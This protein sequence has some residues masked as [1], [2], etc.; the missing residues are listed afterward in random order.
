MFSDPTFITASRDLV[1]VRLESYESKEH[2]TKVRELLHGSFANTAFC[3]LA[4]DGERQLSSAGRSP[5]SL[6]GSRGGRFSGAPEEES[7]R[8]IAQLQVILKDFPP[9]KD[10]SQAV[11]QDFHTFRQALNVASGDQ[12]ILLLTVAS[13]ER[14][15]DLLPTLKKTLNDGKMI[16]RYHH[17]FAEGEG[18]KNWAEQ[19][20]G[21]KT[22]AKSGY[23]IIRPDR[24]GLK[25]EV[26]THLPLTASAG[27]LSAALTQANKD[28]AKD[29]ERKVY[30]DHVREARRNGAYF[31]N[32]VPYGEDRDGDGVIDPKR[33]RGRG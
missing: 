19:V 13:P 18:D 28:Y 3:V 10:A 2:Q 4:P 24:F 27:E 16:G 17:D 30:R 29:E 21:E 32:A 11:V 5:A 12:R 8:T 14:R 7:K 15:S 25:G 22:D 26:V 20:A 31:E 33:G 1:C 6:F 23:L 9:R